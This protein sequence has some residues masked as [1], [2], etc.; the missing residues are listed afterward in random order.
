MVNL[1]LFELYL[2]KKKKRTRVCWK[3]ND[4]KQWYFIIFQFNGAQ[5]PSSVFW[6]KR[7][8]VTAAFSKHHHSNKHGLR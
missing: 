8:L 5:E 6:M 1:V 7:R 3:G 2:K 4:P